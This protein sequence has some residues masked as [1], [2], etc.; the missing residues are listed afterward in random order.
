MRATSS[1]TT[2]ATTSSA[3]FGYSTL[4]ALNPSFNPKLGNQVTKYNLLRILLGFGNTG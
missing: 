4:Q 3:V 2:G 1:P